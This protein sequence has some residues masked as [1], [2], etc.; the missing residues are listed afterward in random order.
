M[1]RGEK[2][3]L[4]TGLAFIS[5][6]V[7][8]F[9]VLSVYPL[10]ASV[11]FSFTEYS[12]LS[13]A[14]FVGGRNY[15]DMVA[16]EVFW[17][18]LSNTLF[19][20]AI[21]VPLGL[22]LA[23]A[24]AVLLNFD[25]GGKGIFRTVFFLPSLVPMVCLA[26]IWQWMLNGDLGLVNAALRPV[27]DFINSLTGASLQPPNWLADARF[28]KWGLVFT[29]LWGI[30]NAVVIF[31]AALQD[32]PRQLY[33]SAELDGAD[34]W[35][36][37]WHITLPTI[38]PVILFNLIMGIIGAFQVFAVPYVMTGGGDGPERSLLFLATYL[39][40]NAF[41]YWNMGYAC[42]L[43]VVLF[44]LIL[45]LTLLSLKTSSRH[46]HYAGK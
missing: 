37:T 45:S 21:A 26:V 40:Q 39:Y 22:G 18:A 25:V 29:V 38:S 7:L 20:A 12:V 46:V 28:A 2:K 16:D 9:L 5:P 11:G 24:L 4:L 31:L 44:F 17:T 43:G 13:P 42:A 8:G 33:E 10:A 14:V 41:D 36:K 35:G 1:T 15:A 27:L 32:V 30:G 3:S 19:F 23:L 6:W 34:F